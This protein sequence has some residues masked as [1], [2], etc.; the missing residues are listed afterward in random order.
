MKAIRIITTF[1]FLAL[2][3]VWLDFY[4]KS[5]VNVFTI[6]RFKNDPCQGSSNRNGTCYTESECSDRGGSNAGSCAQVLRNIYE[7]L[8]RAWLNMWILFF[9]FHIFCK[10]S[11]FNFRVSVF[12][13]HVSIVMLAKYSMKI[14]FTSLIK[15]PQASSENEKILI[16]IKLAIFLTIQRFKIKIHFLL[17]QQMISGNVLCENMELNWKYIIILLSFSDNNFWGYWMIILAR[18]SSNQE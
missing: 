8:F 5:T 9:Y 1:F 13:A 4:S 11:L 15:N 3:Y 7:H 6:V 12:A 2:D 10:S 17:Q 16:F 14:W 18:S